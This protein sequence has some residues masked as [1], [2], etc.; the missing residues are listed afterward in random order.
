MERHGLWQ[1][2][3]KRG[4]TG[5]GF[6]VDSGFC[7]VERASVRVGRMFLGWGGRPCRSSLTMESSAR[8]NNPS[9]EWLIARNPATDLEIAR[10]AATSSDQVRE[11]I[12]KTKTAAALWSK[13]P[14][15]ERIAILQRWWK[16]LCGEVEPLAN[17]IRSE[18][19]KPLPEAQMEVTA[20]LDAIRWIV[21]NAR[22][23]LADQTLKP[24]WQRLALMSPARLRWTPFGV[25]GI[26]GTW[27]YPVF[28]DASAIAAALVT[29]NGVAWKPS[30]LSIQVASL[31]RETLLKAEVPD[32]L[33]ACLFGGPEI[34]QALIDGD[35]QKGFFTGGSTNGRMI[36]A[37]LAARGI[38]CV[39]E[40][41]GFD[42]AIVR[43]DAPAD[44]TLRGLLWASFVGAGQTCVA[45]K[46]IYIVGDAHKFASELANRTSQLRVGNPANGDVDIGPMISESARARFHQQLASTVMAGAEVLSGGEP[47]EGSGSFYRPTVLFATNDI[48]EKLLEGI[49]GPVVLVRG[50]EDDQ[51][52]IE[53]V[54]AS[55]YGLSASVWSVDRKKAASIARQLN[56][57]MVTIND[58]VTPTGLA[59]APF[60]GNGASGYGRVRGALGLREFASPQVIHDR[61][62]GG[63]RP[64]LFPYSPRFARI[65][66]VYRRLFHRS[67]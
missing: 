58:A 49:F 20:T 42:A 52:A 18:I 48:P 59:S 43:D 60:G 22:F 41:S 36:A 34:G 37:R 14:L 27:N 56:C 47:I 30:E 3:R 57:G 38:P 23:V 9:T 39:C 62:P 1:E 8:M 55:H 35:I 50:V 40:L 12:S 15:G 64:Q 31:L 25:V 65:L 26:I 53:A 54:N 21:K 67:P 61:R 4:A 2:A 63:F 29:G 13:R 10:V 44:S 17:A 24:G 16:V 66:E 46:R 45:V 51:R 32:G 7:K 33:V 6:P 19:G 11:Q 28:L 5:V